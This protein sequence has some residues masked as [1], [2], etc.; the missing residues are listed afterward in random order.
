MEKQ[1]GVS[2]ATL[3]AYL[4]PLLV[5]ERNTAPMMNGVTADVGRHRILYCQAHELVF[6]LAAQHISEKLANPRNNL[7]FYVCQ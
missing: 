1:S 6:T 5:S 7:A 2:L 4:V 3:S